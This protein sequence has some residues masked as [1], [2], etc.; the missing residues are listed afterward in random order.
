MPNI[1][2]EP[3]GDGYSMVFADY[4]SPNRRVFLCQVD[5]A[6]LDALEQYFVSN[7]A[8]KCTEIPL[9]NPSNYFCHLPNFTPEVYSETIS[10]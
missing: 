4:H 3:C 10:S 7:R 1:V 5:D 6:A 9:D 8:A 2:V